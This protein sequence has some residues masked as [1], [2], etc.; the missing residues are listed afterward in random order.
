MASEFLKLSQHI[1]KRLR[2]KIAVKP[3]AKRAL[4]GTSLLLSTY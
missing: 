2:S 3:Y 1:S 4:L